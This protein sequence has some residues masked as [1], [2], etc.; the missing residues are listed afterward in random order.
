MMEV[1]HSKS[2][3]MSFCL[4]CHRHPEKALRP[5]GEV[6]NLAWTLSADSESANADGDAIHAHAGA[7]I[8]KNWGVNPSLS[9]TGCHR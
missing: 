3:S 4:K 9:C 6:T 5:M 2:L 8:R 1:Y 7:D